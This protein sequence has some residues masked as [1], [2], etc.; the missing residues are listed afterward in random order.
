MSE[1]VEVLGPLSRV[2]VGCNVAGMLRSSR[3]NLAEA[4][5]HQRPSE[6]KNWEFKVN[7]RR[8]SQQKQQQQKDDGC[9][10]SADSAKEAA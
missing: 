6:C 2:R 4:H 1:C 3:H 7:E 8:G 9:P 10:V 5:T